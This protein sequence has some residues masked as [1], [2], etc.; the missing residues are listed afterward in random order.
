MKLIFTVMGG[1]ADEYGEAG[2]YQDR[3]SLRFEDR[4]DAL[5]LI[6]DLAHALQTADEH[7][8]EMGGMFML[9]RGVFQEVRE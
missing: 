1:E 7:L 2:D 3:L 5:Q 6:A 8:N 9:R 4:D